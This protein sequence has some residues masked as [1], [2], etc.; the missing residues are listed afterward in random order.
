MKGKKTNI[1]ED[2]WVN[3]HNYPQIDSNYDS[4]TEVI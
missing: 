3:N 4:D 2:K 1:Q